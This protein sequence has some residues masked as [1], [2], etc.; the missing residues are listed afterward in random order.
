VF[1][2]QTSLG[3]QVPRISNKARKKIISKKKMTFEVE[4][5]ALIT[6]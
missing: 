2:E 1:L 6:R 3:Q 5:K 4:T